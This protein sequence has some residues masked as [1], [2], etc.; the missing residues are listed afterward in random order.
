[1]CYLTSFV[2]WQQFNFLRKLSFHLERLVWSH[3]GQAGDAIPSQLRSSV[4]E[5]ERNWKEN[6]FRTCWLGIADA[7]PGVFMNYLVSA[8]AN[9][10]KANFREENLCWLI[11]VMEKTT[12]KDWT[13]EETSKTLLLLHDS[14]F[15]FK[16]NNLEYFSSFSK[17]KINRTNKFFL[18]SC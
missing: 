11:F 13:L 8:R 6:I 15:Y 10:L 7:F 3:L 4:H 14:C 18:T 17:N 2:K 9:I 5:M 16:V 12:K 1:M